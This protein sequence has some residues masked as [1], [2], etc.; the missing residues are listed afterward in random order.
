[1][2]ASFENSAVKKELICTQTKA[3]G[4]CNV[5]CGPEEEMQVTQLLGCVRS[6]SRDTVLTG[7]GATGM[8]RG[9]VKS[10]GVSAVGQLTQAQSSRIWRVSAKSSR[11]QFRSQQR[12]YPSQAG[13]SPTGYVLLRC[14]R[15]LGNIM[16]RHQRGPVHLFP[17][18][19]RRGGDVVVLQ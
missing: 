11:K 12:Q 18:P 6:P 17:G 4:R 2:H 7:W 1:M 3:P 5:V 16:P 9:S 19:D 15:A 14:R 10:F 8:K 13:I